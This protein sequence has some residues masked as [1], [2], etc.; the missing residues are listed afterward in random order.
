MAAWLM[1]DAVCRSPSLS[2]TVRVA[3][4]ASGNLAND[5]ST[6]HGASNACG[7]YRGDTKFTGS[8]SP[9]SAPR[10]GAVLEAWLLCG[11]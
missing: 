6:A 10:R 2:R 4:G 7:N 3:M 8:C 1:Q 9:A 11:G 5:G